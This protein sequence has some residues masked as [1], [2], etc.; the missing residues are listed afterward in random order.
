LEYGAITNYEIRPESKDRLRCRM[1]L[2]GC[3]QCFKILAET[4]LS[5]QHSILL[6]PSDF[7]LF[8]TLKEFLDDKP[9]KSN[10]EMKDAVKERLNGLAAKA[11]R[12]SSQAMTNV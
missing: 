4:F 9:F 5:I 6:A 10:K 8:P 1:L 11:Y 12:N 3:K 7:Y 2:P